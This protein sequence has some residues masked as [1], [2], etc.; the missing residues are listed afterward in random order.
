M[1]QVLDQCMSEEVV[2]GKYLID[3]A[4]LKARIERLFDRRM[5]LEIPLDPINL[6]TPLSI[7]DPE[8]DCFS[9]SAVQDMELLLKQ[10]GEACL[11]CPSLNKDQIDGD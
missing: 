7:F 3:R 1:Y 4:Q 9:P 8:R 5:Y 2:I 11:T 10:I 6:F